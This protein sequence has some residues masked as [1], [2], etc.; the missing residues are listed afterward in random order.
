MANKATRKLA[1]S[2]AQTDVGSFK[3]W[4]QDNLSATDE[5]G[6]PTARRLILEK[7]GVTALDS[8]V[9]ANGKLLTIA[10]DAFTSVAASSLATGTGNP[11][12]YSF[13]DISTRAITSVL[14]RFRGGGPNDLKYREASS[15][16]DYKFGSCGVDHFIDGLWHNE[17]ERFLWKRDNLLL[18]PNY[19]YERR[20]RL[21]VT[22]S[23]FDWAIYD[24]GMR[25]A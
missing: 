3:K 1:T 16:E 23:A 20:I 9:K 18:V 22:N 12:A 7:A 2:V 11:L 13:V 24:S 6:D 19:G 8:A 10:R 4:V 17:G 15:T 14:V 5:N 25:K 21:F